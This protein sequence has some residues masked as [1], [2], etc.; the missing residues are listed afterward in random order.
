MHLSLQRVR[1]IKTIEL[2]LENRC[3][4]L[5]CVKLGLINNNEAP[6]HNMH[7]Y[8]RH[9]HCWNDVKTVQ[10]ERMDIGNY[11]MP[12]LSA[13]ISTA[14]YWISEWLTDS[15]RNRW[16]AVLQ[17]AGNSSQYALTPVRCKFFTAMA[18]KPDTGG[19]SA[20]WPDARSSKYSILNPKQCILINTPRSMPRKSHQSCKMVKVD[21]ISC[22]TH[23][24]TQS[25]YIRICR[26]LHTA[27]CFCLNHINYS[28]HVNLQRLT[29]KLKLSMQAVSKWNALV[30]ENKKYVS[31]TDLWWDIG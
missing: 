28:L 11:C 12:V 17:A 18:G 20:H 26:V 24:L 25:S 23:N 3:M 7:H 30:H 8:W 29:E 19:S 22:C 10:Y 15:L 5:S 14:V 27:M 31:V 21:K 16:E 1:C 2:I 6:I 9:V 4:Q 13:I